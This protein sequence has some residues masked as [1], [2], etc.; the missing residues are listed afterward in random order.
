MK[1]L[2]LPLLAAL[3]LP[4]AVSAGD[5]GVADFENTP[6]GKGRLEL[7]DKDDRSQGFGKMLCGFFQ[8]VECEIEFKDG[9]LIVNDSKGITP[10]QI[11]SFFNIIPDNNWKTRGLNIVYKG[12]NGII[13]RASFYL[14]GTHAD[15]HRFMKEF[16]YFLNQETDIPDNYF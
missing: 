1:R 10:N 7:S 12:N 9:R 5:L 14:M 15:H 2:L 8:L 13:T 11:I 6:Q 3:A 4:T 16:L